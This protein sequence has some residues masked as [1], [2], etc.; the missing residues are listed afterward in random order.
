LSFAT[1]IFLMTFLGVGVPI[2]LAKIKQQESL[3]KIRDIELFA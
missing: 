2:F 3:A 1:C